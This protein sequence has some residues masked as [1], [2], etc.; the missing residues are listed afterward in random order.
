[1]F[2]KQILQNCLLN[3]TSMYHNLNNMINAYEFMIYKQKLFD[4]SIN[5]K[6]WLYV[7]DAYAFGK[8]TI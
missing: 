4:S 5:K 2:W 3:T 8:I 1:M 7:S 6:K